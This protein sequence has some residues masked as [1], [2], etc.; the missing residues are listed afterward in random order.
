M[1]EPKVSG[2]H[3]TRAQEDNGRAVVRRGVRCECRLKWKTLGTSEK[4]WTGPCHRNAARLARR[5][6]NNNGEGRRHCLGRCAHTFQTSLP[7]P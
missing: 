1:E 2:R 7:S 6:M 4:P 5:K 3:Q